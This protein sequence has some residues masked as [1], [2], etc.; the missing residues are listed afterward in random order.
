M[1]KINTRSTKDIYCYT[2]VINHLID[3]HDHEYYKFLEEP[4]N[5]ILLEKI[6]KYRARFPKKDLD[7]F[8]KRSHSKEYIKFFMENKK[9]KVIKLLKQNI[10]RGDIPC[11]VKMSQSWVNKVIREFS[12]G[13]IDK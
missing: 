2:R 12:T 1:S 9:E 6:L 8:E 7:G 4:S 3:K 11:L 13:N 10:D 5:T